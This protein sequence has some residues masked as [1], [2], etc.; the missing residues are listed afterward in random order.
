[1]D[2]I[3]HTNDFKKFFCANLLKVGETCFSFWAVAATTLPK[4]DSPH[5]FFESFERR[6][7]EDIVIRSKAKKDIHSF[8]FGLDS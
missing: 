6:K 8:R 5:F 3:N 4:I 2:H 1:M 7:N